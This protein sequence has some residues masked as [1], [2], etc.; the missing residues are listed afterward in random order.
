M[1]LHPIDYRYNVS[2]LEDYLS[3]ESLLKYMLKV[4]SAYT[5][6]LADVG[7][8]S[9]K[10]ANEISSKANL[11]NIKYKEW[12]KK[13]KII[14]HDTRAMVQLLQE[15]VSDSAKPYVHLGLTSNDVVDTAM[16]L[17]LKDAINYV[18]I[19]DMTDLEKILIYS[20]RK[21]KS[22][23]QIGRTHGQHA[24]PTTFGRE[25][26]VYVDRFGNR[27]S[28]IKKETDNL[29]GKISGAIG[30]KASFS[31]FYDNPDEIERLTLKKLG[32][33][34][35]S[36]T[37]QIIPKEYEADFFGEIVKTHGV[38]SDL[39]ND[40]RQLQR[41]EIQEVEEEFLKTQI[42]SSTMPHKRNPDSFENIC[43][44][45]RKTAPSLLSVLLNIESEHQRDMRDSAARRYYFVEILVPFDYSVKRMS[46]LMNHLK[47]NE[48]AM[49]KNL[50]LTKGNILAEPLYISLALSD[51]GD[52]HEYLR[53]LTALQRK[54]S[55]EILKYDVIKQAIERLSEEKQKI[56]SNPSLYIGSSEKLV[57]E[58]CDFWDKRTSEI[59][60]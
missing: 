34:A 57:D 17:M 20:S 26:A 2:E 43:S 24:I 35:T 12:L 32:L 18:I 40:I 25:L 8:C 22:I 31:L 7:T 44:Q 29:R 60:K 47:V 27:I 37:T 15:S 54:S 11:K 59:S 50:S 33:N 55:E 51:R 16:N 56:F 45:Y 3:H 21:Y 6:A 58:V 13:E 36:I 5:E 48:N 23:V 41:T 9:R 1:V 42:G 49:K 19:P 14:A 39:A 4:E 28:R 53:K 10:I 52:A 30:T 46:D 38:I